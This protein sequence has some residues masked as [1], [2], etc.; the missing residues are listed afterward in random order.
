MT[1]V[2]AARGQWREAF[3]AWLQELITRSTDED[4]QHLQEVRDLLDDSQR[5]DPGDAAPASP[6][7]RAGELRRASRERARRE[8]IRRDATRYDGGLQGWRPAGR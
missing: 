8:S 7:S 5:L 1:I 3:V 4:Q 6:G 2:T